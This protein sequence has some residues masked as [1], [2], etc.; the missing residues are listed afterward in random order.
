VSATPPPGPQGGG[1]VPD[2]RPAQ[3][4]QQASPP[5]WALR[6]PHRQRLHVVAAARK[7]HCDLNRHVPRSSHGVSHHAYKQSNRHAHHPRQRWS[8]PGH[9]RAR[10]S[11][12]AHPTQ[13]PV[14][15]VSLHI[16]RSSRW[17]ASECRV[18]IQ[19]PCRPCT[20][21]PR[22]QACAPPPAP[23]SHHLQRGRQILRRA[24]HALRLMH[25][26]MRALPPSSPAR[27]LHPR[28]PPRPRPLPTFC[29]TPGRSCTTRLMVCAVMPSSAA[30]LTSALGASCSHG[31]VC[32][33]GGGVGH[34]RE[35][36]GWGMRGRSHGSSTHRRP[37]RWCSC[38][39][40]PPSEMHSGGGAA[41]RPVSHALVIRDSPGCWRARPTRPAHRCPLGTRQRRGTAGRLLACRWACGRM[42]GSGV[43]GRGVRA[44][45]VAEQYGCAAGGRGG[46]GG[47]LLQCQRSLHVARRA[48]A[49]QGRRQAAPRRG[50]L[51]PG[52][53][54]GSRWVPSCF[55]TAPR[56]A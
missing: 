10:A 34:A 9:R 26:G 28:P 4:S 22:Q 49:V 31:G 54:R 33:G 30:A 20:T 3:P 35:G 7:H 11:E 15:C 53:G 24:A 56:R 47:S 18:A 40:C 21:R 44:H 39:L 5:T 14:V 2:T 37:L 45:R 38:R 55:P 41:G 50:A 32:T 27:F 19:P 16:P 13:Q 17:C 1:G 51:T 23:A 42:G 6:R 43:S 12:R 52:G 36:A 46:G 48:P 8:G 25:E 29:S